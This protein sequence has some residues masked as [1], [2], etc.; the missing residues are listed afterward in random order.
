MLKNQSSQKTAIQPY[1]NKQKIRKKY[2]FFVKTTLYFGRLTHFQTMEK[3]VEGL[4]YTGEVEPNAQ[5]CSFAHPI[6]QLQAVK[7]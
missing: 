3:I 2:F 4:L 6:F 1:R 5:G 7:R